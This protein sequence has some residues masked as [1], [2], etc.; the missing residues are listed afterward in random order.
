MISILILTLNE[1]IN[2]EAC[3]KSVAFSDDIVILD[4][5]SSDGTEV[6]AHKHNLTFIKRPFDNYASQRNFGLTH[7]FKNEW[8]LMLDADE[9]V[10]EELRVE[11][12]CR[13]SACG[14][15]T[16]LFRMRRKDFFM[17]RWLKRSSGY[18]TW[19]GRLFRRGTLR[20]EREIN[21]EYHTDGSVEFLQEH[22]LHFPFNKGISYW[23]ERHNRYSS[24]EANSLLVEQSLPVQWG[25][26]YSSDPSVR[27]KAFKQVAYRFPFRPFFTFCYLCIFRG[28][29]LDG[30]AGVHYSFL[31]LFYEY[32]INLKIKELKH[33][34][35]IKIEALNSE[36]ASGDQ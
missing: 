27:R 35:A 29:F 26:F 21:E 18:P 31:R 12:E 16:S 22:L 20:V 9:R 19:F 1:E 34:K 10:N 15:S 30:F 11:M 14:V 17:G 3:I 24:M 36:S 2:L 8:V 13:I 28:G 32:L 7:S 33:S 25:F 4:S 5:I 6:I 23:V